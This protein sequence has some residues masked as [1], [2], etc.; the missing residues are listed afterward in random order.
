MEACPGCWGLGHRGARRAEPRARDQWLVW[1]AL[2]FAAQRTTCCPKL[3]FLVSRLFPQSEGRGRGI[4]APSEELTFATQFKSLHHCGSERPAETSEAAPK[5][6]P[7]MGISPLPPE[8][9]ACISSSGSGFSLVD[10]LGIHFRS[11]LTKAFR[12]LKQ[13]GPSPGSQRSRG[14]QKTQLPPP[15]LFTVYFAPFTAF[16][17]GLIIPSSRSKGGLLLGHLAR[18]CRGARR[19]R[20]SLKDVYTEGNSVGTRLVM[21]RHRT[22][23]AGTT[24]PTLLPLREASCRK[25][26]SRGCGGPWETWVQEGLIRSEG[27]PDGGGG[28]EG[29]AE[30][31]RARGEGR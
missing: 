1:A 27:V 7:G 2:T 4:V 9:F 17:A 19:G 22:Q 30:Q 12:R 3:Q 25:C 16:R 14:R 21:A 8:R 28:R 13:R 6:I 23:Q 29:P 11:C 26:Q 15:P 18:H 24:Q 10:T 31:R 5:R 20:V